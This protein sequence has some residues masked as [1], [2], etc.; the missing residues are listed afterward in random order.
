MYLLNMLKYLY[1][2]VDTYQYIKRV[3]ITMNCKLIFLQLNTC[4][5]YEPYCMHTG[6]KDWR[7]L[8]QLE[9][10]CRIELGP[11]THFAKPPFKE[12]Q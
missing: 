1:P 10:V 7:G 4:W 12:P 3:V 5:L 2:S 9:S 8:G 11:F 6:C